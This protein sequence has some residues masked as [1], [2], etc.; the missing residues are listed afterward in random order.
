MRRKQDAVDTGRF[1]AAQKRADVLRILERIEHEHEWRFPALERSGKHVV[2]AGPASRL[3]DEGDPLVAIE[4]RDG[5]QRAALD[6][7]DGDPQGRRMEDQPLEGL[8]SLRHDEQ[9]AGGASGDERLLDRAS[10]GDELFALGE[11][12]RRRDSRPIGI[13]RTARSVAPGTITGGPA[14]EWSALA[15]RSPVGWARAVVG[16][17][18]GSGPE[19][20]PAAGRALAPITERRPLVAV[21]AAPVVGWSSDCVGPV[22]SERRSRL[23]PPAEAAG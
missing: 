5:G 21:R 2:D 3:D 15:R 16:R 11:Q 10:P 12:V 17:A 22:P 8:T 6:F 4:A 19:R 9:P 18:A 7:D 13:G 1:R 20:W 14:T 23:G